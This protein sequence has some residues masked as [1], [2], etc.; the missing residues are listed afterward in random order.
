MQLPDSERIRKL[1]ERVLELETQAK[2]IRFVGGGVTLALI[3]VIFRVLFG[4]G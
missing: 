1:E 4:G 3:G 2:V